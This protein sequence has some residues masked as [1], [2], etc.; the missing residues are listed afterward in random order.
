M[1][2]ELDDF[3]DE[4]QHL[5]NIY[6]IDIKGVNGAITL[7][8]KYQGCEEKERK[9]YEYYFDC[10]GLGLELV[11]DYLGRLSINGIQIGTVDTFKDYKVKLN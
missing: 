4:E 9:Y 1:E 2:Y 3:Q 7:Y 6:E 5:G 11:I 8:A 10:I